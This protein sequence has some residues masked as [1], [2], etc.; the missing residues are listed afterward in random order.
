[1]TDADEPEPAQQLRCRTLAEPGGSEPHVAKV[2]YA[3]SMRAELSGAHGKEHVLRD[4]L[5]R[6]GFGAASESGSGAAATKRHRAARRHEADGLDDDVKCSHEGCPKPT[7]YFELGD[8]DKETRA[9]LDE[10]TM[11]RCSGCDFNTHLIHLGADLRAQ[12]RKTAEDAIKTDAAGFRFAWRV[13]EFEWSAY[14]L[15]S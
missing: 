15:Y 11:L 4:S 10:W 5:Y 14:P 7:A 1:M 9:R 8:K 6:T 13:A 12:A 3:K 2:A